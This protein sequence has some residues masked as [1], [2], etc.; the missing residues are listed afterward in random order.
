M[1]AR[2]LSKVERDF[3]PH[4]GSGGSKMKAM[5]ARFDIL[6]FWSVEAYYIKVVV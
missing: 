1:R 4:G 2:A 3:G 6:G 5:E